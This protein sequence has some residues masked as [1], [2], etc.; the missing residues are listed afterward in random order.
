MQKIN[1]LALDEN[2]DVVSILAYENLQWTRKFFETGWFS[3]QIPSNQYNDNIKYIYTKDRPEIGVVSQKNYRITNNAKT[4]NLSGFFAEKELDRMIV[5]PIGEGNIVNSPTWSMQKG[6]SED[7]ALKFFDDFKKI[8]YNNDGIKSVELNISTRPSR[9]R[10][11]RSEHSR[12]SENLGHKLYKILK[13]SNLSYRI[14]FDFFKKTKELEVWSGVDRTVDNVEK[15][16][17]IVFSTKYGN[18]ENID[19]LI[20]ETEEKT[21]YI[22]TGTYGEDKRIV[23]ADAQGS[24]STFLHF[25]SSVNRED[26]KSQSEFKNAIAKNGHAEVLKHKKVFS[27]DFKPVLGSYEYRKDFDLGDICTVEVPE[28]SVSESAILT[29]CIETIKNGQWILTMEFEVIK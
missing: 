6:K 12:N 20:S 28:M 21:A 2:F 25:D 11:K 16:N 13:F 17:Q 3:I 26:F 8:S 5:Y 24:E 7:V 10:G 9:G 23:L 22:A 18:V 1:I 27:L 14:V 15:N 29:G 4:V 19:I